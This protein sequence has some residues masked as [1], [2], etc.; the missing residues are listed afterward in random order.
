MNID[1]LTEAMQRFVKSRGWYEQHSPK[2]QTLKNLS[3][4][5]LLETAELLEYFQ[6]SDKLDEPSVLAEEIADVALYLLQIS[7][8]AGIDLEAAILNKLEANYQ[9]EWKL[10]SHNSEDEQSKKETTHVTVFGGSQPQPTDRAYQQALRLGQMLGESGYSVLT[11]GYIGTMEAVSRGAYEAGA[12]VI[13]VTCDEIE[14]WRPVGPNNWIKEEIRFPTLRQ[15][16]FAL[17]EKCHAA[18]ALPGGIGTLVEIGTMWSQIQTNVISP[19]PL[20]LIGNEWRDIINTMFDQL[21]NY[22]PMSDRRYLTFSPDVDS[23]VRLLKE[24]LESKHI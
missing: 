22:I 24:M 6:W 7:N 10:Q 1:D 20:I 23:A 14:R 13:G 21:G 5:M 15:R 9:R 16:V 3:I 2:P 17:I 12:H 8:M 18:L 11:G 4:S 19:R